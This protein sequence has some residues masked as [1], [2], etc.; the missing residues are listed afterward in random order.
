[1]SL[2]PRLFPRSMLEM[3][4]WFRPS[5]DIF[6]PFDELD[7]MIGRNL[8]WLVRPSFM[9]E[10]KPRLPEKYRITV[11]CAGYKP[12]SLKTEFKDNKLIVSGIEEYKDSDDFSKREFKKTYKIPDNAEVDKLRSFFAGKHLVVELPLKQKEL[13][14]NEEDQEDWFPQIVDGDSGTKKVSLNT[15]VPKGIDPSK[16]SVTCK[17]RDLIIK[18]EDKVEKEDS[19]SLTYFYKHYRLP[20]NT[21]FNALKCELKDSKLSIQAPLNSAVK[22]EM[23][24]PIQQF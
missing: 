16:M 3:D 13:G 6:D 24:I 18:A 9:T 1:M 17:D 5:L 12:E 11:N 8:H 4:N 23:K 20:E 10:R 7:N 21:D 19:F 22:S 2:I 15:F 14:T